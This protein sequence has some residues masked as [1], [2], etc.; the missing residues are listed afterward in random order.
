MNS[1]NNK[2]SKRG[3]T[4]LRKALYQDTCEG[5]YKRSSGY[6]NSLLKAYYD[7]KISEG[8][9]SKATIIATFNK[10]LRIV[11]GISKSCKLFT[12]NK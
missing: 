6:A 8:K 5:I 2:I 3:S 1:S 9:P 4:Y 10:L 12:M 11:H 7:K